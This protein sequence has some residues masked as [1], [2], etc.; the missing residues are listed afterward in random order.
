MYVLIAWA[1]INVSGWTLQNGAVVSSGTYNTTLSLAW[2][3][4]HRFGVF[5]N[6]ILKKEAE[7]QK[8]RKLHEFSNLHP[9]PNIDTMVT[10]KIT[11]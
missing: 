1:I 4:E 3:E 6:M 5:Q 8:L 9:S 7:N 10:Q 11:R 2:K